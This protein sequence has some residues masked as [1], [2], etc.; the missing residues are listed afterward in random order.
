VEGSGSGLLKVIHIIFL[1]E[2]YEK[3]EKLNSG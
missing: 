2:N 3:N 1:V